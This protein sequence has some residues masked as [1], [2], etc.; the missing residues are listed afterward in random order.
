MMSLGK[1]CLRVWSGQQGLK[2]VECVVFHS[3][4]PS[5]IQH[6]ASPWTAE[7]MRLHSSCGGGDWSQPDLHDEKN[8]V[9]NLLRAISNQKPPTVPQPSPKKIQQTSSAVFYPDVVRREDARNR[10]VGLLI[11]E[12]YDKEWEISCMNI[13]EGGW[14]KTNVR[15]GESKHED[16]HKGDGKQVAG[17][18]AV[19]G[20]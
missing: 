20:D 1:V 6:N 2:D 19:E 5:R 17:N 7:I 14:G 16:R 9:I 4:L 13:S 3:F 8:R 11:S 12:E 18:D 15:D 10:V